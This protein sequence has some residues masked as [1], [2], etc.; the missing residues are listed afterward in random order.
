MKEELQ[1][2]LVEILTQLQDAVKTGADF[3]IEQLPDIVQQYIIFG[4]VFNTVTAV[5][6]IGLLIGSYYLFRAAL[7]EVK[8]DLYHQQDGVIIG[9]WLGGGTCSFVGVALIFA[10]IKNL[11][12]VWFA[13][14]I[15]LLF[16]ISRLIK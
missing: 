6:G 1:L 4:R 5:F 3:A 7:K 8:K 11:I 2:K 10:N 14:K 9:G 15:W 12:L 13:P 16:E